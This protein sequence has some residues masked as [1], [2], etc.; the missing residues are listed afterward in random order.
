MA[1]QIFVNLPVKDLDRSVAFFTK[2]GFRFDPQ[3]TDENA[4]CMIVCENIYVMLLVE[5]F[6]QSFTKKTICDAR[7]CTEAIVCLSVA[8]RA[9]VDGMVAKAVGA[10]G[11]VPNEPKD[12]GFMYGHGFEDLDGHLWEV[13]YMDAKSAHRS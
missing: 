3:F 11:A 4:T 5:E 6:F 9:E 13:M 1:T 12:Y 8:S 7:Q 10:G 2:L